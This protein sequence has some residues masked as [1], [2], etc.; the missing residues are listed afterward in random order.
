MAVLW[1]QRGSSNSWAGSGRRRSHVQGGKTSKNAKVASVSR[2]P[3][4]LDVFVVGNNGIVYTAPWDQN[5]FQGKWR[6][7]WKIVP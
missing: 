2:D 4:K 6:G 1:K 7:W 3:S 5:V